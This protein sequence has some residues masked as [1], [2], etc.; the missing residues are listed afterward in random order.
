MLNDRGARC[1]RVGRGT[2]RAHSLHEEYGGGVDRGQER[3]GLGY[4]KEYSG[5]EGRTLDIASLG[6]NGEG[7]YLGIV[8]EFKALRRGPAP[9]PATSSGAAPGRGFAVGWIPLPRVHL[10]AGT[11]AKGPIPRGGH[12]AAGV[13]AHGQGGG[14]DARRARQS[15]GQRQVPYAPPARE[16]VPIMVLKF[17][18][19]MVNEK[20]S[21]VTRDFERDPIQPVRAR[22]VDEYGGGGKGISTSLSSSTTRTSRPGQTRWDPVLP[23]NPRSST[24]GLLSGGCPC[25]EFSWPSNNAA[26]QTSRSTPRTCVL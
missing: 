18:L 14:G 16:G 19:D 13:Y 11:Q 6:G 9:S 22:W 4:V 1:T 20:N 25:Q 12:D 2:E 26:R 8:Q 7:A 24:A 21:Y 5:I 23:G 3:V 10:R 15:A 17:H